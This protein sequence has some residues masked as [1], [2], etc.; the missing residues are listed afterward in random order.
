MQRLLLPHIL[1]SN[2]LSLVQILGKAEF[3]NP[4]GSVKDRVALEIVQEAFE[5]G[6]LKRGGLVTEGTVGECTR[7]DVS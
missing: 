5:S 7:S 1:L 6:A 2:H 3:V 4:G